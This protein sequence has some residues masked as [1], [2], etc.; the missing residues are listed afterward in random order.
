MLVQT[1]EMSAWEANAPTRGM[2]TFWK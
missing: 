1:H 2:M